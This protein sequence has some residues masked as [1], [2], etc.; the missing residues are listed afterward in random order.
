MLVDGLRRS[1]TPGRN[2]SD[3]NLHRTVR[4]L[5]YWIFFSIGVV[6]VYSFGAALGESTIGTGVAHFLTRFSSAMLVSGA[7]LAIGI[8]LG[9]LF[10]IPRTV[11][12]ETELALLRAGGSQPTPAP[13]S[14]QSINTNLEQI[15]DWLTKILVGV[16]LTQLQEMPKQLWRLGESFP[17]GE[18]PSLGLTIILS[19]LVSGFF[20]GYLLTRLFLAGAFQ[21]AEYRRTRLT[22]RAAAF[23]EAGA[24]DQA[25]S[26]Y[27]QALGSITVTTAKPEKRRIY[28]GLIF[29]SLYEAP[30]RGFTRAIQYAQRYLT[31]EPG[32]PSATIFA[33]LAAA[34]GQQY[35]YKKAQHVNTEELDSIKASAL[36]AANRAIQADPLIRPLL[37]MMWNPHHSPKSL[38]DNDLEVFYEDQDFKR[39]LG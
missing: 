5:I 23:E 20:C 22:D 32:F 37:Q 34:Y 39:L 27:E 29:N 14:Q 16:G 33:Y 12:Q 36:E 26:E 25:L 9:F 15:S 3:R 38:N 4:S 18:N 2:Q 24:H 17:L 19:F 7:S 30:P 6:L 8:L 35:N 1:G 11:Q 21:E 28:E 13:F 10:G 31:E